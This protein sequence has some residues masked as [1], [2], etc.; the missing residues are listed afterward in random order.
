MMN[1]PCP[2]IPES[3]AFRMGHREAR[4]AAAM[5]ANEADDEIDRLRAEVERLR[6]LLDDF[7]MAAE[8]PG[9]HCELEQAVA[10]AK[11]ALAPP[12]SEAP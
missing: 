12:A 2:E 11:A 5:I 9:D 7:I 6:G 8:L 4:R 10:H 3:A 1:I